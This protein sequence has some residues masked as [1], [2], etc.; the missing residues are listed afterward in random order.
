MPEIPKM[1]LKEPKILA[2]A[3]SADQALSALSEGADSVFYDVFQNDQPKGEVGAYIP[4]AL[5][6]WAAESATGMCANLR[7]PDCLCADLGAASLI[8]E[9]I[10]ILTSTAMHS[11]TST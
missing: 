4:R 6:S 11:M 5:P 10:S 2:L 8:S 3:H 9:K 1:T 7:S